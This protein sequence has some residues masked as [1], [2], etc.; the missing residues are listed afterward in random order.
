[1]LAGRAGEQLFADQALRNV[2]G[3]CSPVEVTDR[4]PHAATTS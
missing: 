3:S 4:S 1:M 2:D